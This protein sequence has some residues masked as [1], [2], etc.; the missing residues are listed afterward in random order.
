MKFSPN[1]RFVILQGLPT[2]KN[3]MLSNI[4]PVPK[5]KNGVTILDLLQGT[6]TSLRLSSTARL[7]YEIS[8][9]SV[10]I[11]R[12]A[13]SGEILVDEFFLPDLEVFD[14]RVVAY[15]PNQ[16][17]CTTCHTILGD[18]C[19]ISAREHQGIKVIAIGHSPFAEARA[20]GD[21][22]VCE[23]LIFKIV[24]PELPVKMV[25]T[26]GSLLSARI[27]VTIPALIDAQYDLLPST[28][29]FSTKMTMRERVNARNGTM[30]TSTRPTTVLQMSL[31]MSNFVD[32]ADKPITANEIPRKW[33][34]YH[35]D[36]LE[37]LEFQDV[38]RN[39]LRRD[40]SLAELSAE[41]GGVV[42]DTWDEFAE[43][44]EALADDDSDHRRK[45]QAFFKD[46]GIGCDIPIY[47]HTFSYRPQ[48]EADTIDFC[49]SSA[50]D[51]G[52]IEEQA[53]WFN[54]RFW[55]NDFTGARM[56]FPF[57]Q[58]AEIDAVKWNKDREASRYRRRGKRFPAL[59]RMVDHI[60]GSIELDTSAGSERRL[61]IRDDESEETT[62]IAVE[63]I[64]EM[65]DFFGDLIDLMPAAG[66]LFKD[67]FTQIM[68][69][70]L[71]RDDEDGMAL[72]DVD[73]EE[74]P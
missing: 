9:H 17:S 68:S 39:A 5:I 57:Y 12:L 27:V 20:A 37:D 35:N 33:Q 26:E 19:Y 52:W 72:E 63:G 29:E 53:E 46:I 71:M 34:Q 1:G 21:T 6:N 55:K 14:R 74:E 65:R 41:L 51:V 54:Q 66:S 4:V 16:C 36:A 28:F 67:R 13:S 48:G 24:S 22:N 69:Q 56:W 2:F 18:T 10:K 49:W 45:M 32:A 61:R 64:F 23:P 62:Q 59:K 70:S 30:A 43:M 47:V 60:R 31:V 15:I 38:L 73:E 50:A 3:D 44:H 40:E 42:P 11:Y 7:S 25:G 8:D 58:Y